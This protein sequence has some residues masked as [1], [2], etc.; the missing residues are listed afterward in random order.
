MR[1]RNQ[2]CEAPDINVFASI[3]AK[4]FGRSMATSS[5]RHLWCTSIHAAAYTN[6]IKRKLLTLIIQIKITAEVDLLR[7]ASKHTHTKKQHLRAHTESCRAVEERERDVCFMQHRF[8]WTDGNGLATTLTA[9][10]AYWSIKWLY[11]SVELVPAP[12][13]TQ[14]QPKRMVVRALEISC[15]RRLNF[16]DNVFVRSSRKCICECH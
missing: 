12:H 7:S 5:T 14:T 11:Y 13:R 3:N 8:T 4:R 9:R 1:F 15:R 6:N 16:Q 10:A 2:F